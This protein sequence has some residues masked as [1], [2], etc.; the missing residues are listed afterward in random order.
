MVLGKTSL[1]HRL[2][3]DEVLTEDR[4]NS[5]TID[6]SNYYGPFSYKDKLICI[7]WFETRVCNNCSKKSV[8][9]T[10]SDTFKSCMYD[11]DTIMYQTNTTLF[12]A[13]TR[14]TCNGAKYFTYVHVH[15]LWQ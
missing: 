6:A 15:T 10:V 7:N 2:Q 9:V 12:V 13:S 14:L 3:T 8:K 5:V 11:V 1:I 4:L